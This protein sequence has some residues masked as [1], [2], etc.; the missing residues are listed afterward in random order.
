MLARFERDGSSKTKREPFV[1]AGNEI[2]GWRRA[3][4]LRLS[5]DAELSLRYSTRFSSRLDVV[6]RESHPVCGSRRGGRCVRC[7]LRA[8]L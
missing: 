7:R 1:P 5:H 4:L 2:P 3:E 6:R 8:K